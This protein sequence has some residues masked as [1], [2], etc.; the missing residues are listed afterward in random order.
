MSLTEI[1]INRPSLI[2]VIFSVLTLGGLFAYSQLGYQLMPDFAPPT[3]TIT[4]V[5]PGAS[6]TEVESAVTKKLEDALAELDGVD[7]ITSRTSRSLENASILIVNFKFGTDLDVAMQD[8]QRKID[9]I[10]KDLPEDARPPIMLNVGPKDLP[11]MQISATAKLP[12]P[13]QTAR[14]GVFQEDGR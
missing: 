7:D 1:A 2:I 12:G 6:P 11:I 10:K 5:Y 13:G 3:V 9:N 8:A 4:T 14:P